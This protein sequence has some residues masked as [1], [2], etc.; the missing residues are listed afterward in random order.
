MQ[1]QF[2]VP[3]GGEF[4]IISND[5]AELIDTRFLGLPEGAFL[6]PGGVLMNIS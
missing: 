4:I 1:P 2:A 5:L 3:V 6:S